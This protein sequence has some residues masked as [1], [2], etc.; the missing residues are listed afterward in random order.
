M[1]D[2]LD[3][4]AIFGYDIENQVLIMT[5]RFEL[6]QMFL[7]IKIL[8]S[9]AYQTFLDGSLQSG[10]PFLVFFQKTKSGPNHFAGIVITT[11]LNGR[12]YKIFK[13][14]A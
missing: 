3:F 12:A 4:D 8:V 1:K 13:I 10:Y 14:T 7:S 9:S 5:G 6:L 2:S 11:R